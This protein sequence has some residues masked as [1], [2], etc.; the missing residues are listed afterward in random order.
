M[1]IIHLLYE[2]FT[3]RRI[4][5]QEVVASIEATVNTQ[6]RQV[7]PQKT[8]WLISTS[9]LLIILA[10]ILI[11]GKW[12]FNK[13]HKML[14]YEQYKVENLHKRLKLALETIHQWEV[15]PDLV[16]SRDCNLD[17]LRMRMEEKNFN[18]AIIN[19]V[20]IKIK[21]FI[22]T[23]MRI[24]LSQDKIMGIANL[25]GTKVD[26]ILDVTYENNI[27]GKA[28]RRVLFRIQIKLEKLPKQSTSET[29]KEIIHCIETFLSPEGSNK[30][31]QP[32]IQGYI[33]S[34]SWNQQAKPTP[35]LLLEQHHQG[36]NVSF[37]TKRSTKN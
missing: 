21:Q 20:K 30:N 18:Y 8:I 34:I 37:R 1:P 26:E 33:V 5:R 24:H 31:W 9:S 19:Q 28:N 12:K 23:A 35:L 16:H 13:M 7:F 14:K 3:Q 25:K 15:N 17:Y 36:M 22:S 10:G 6:D 4:S 11:Y 27:E 2:P 32:V 29:I